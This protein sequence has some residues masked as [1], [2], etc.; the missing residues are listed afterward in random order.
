M[1][2]SNKKNIM[3]TPKLIAATIP[4]AIILSLTMNSNDMIVSTQNVDTVLLQIE[5][6][7]ENIIDATIPQDAT[8]LFSVA[9]GESLAGLLGAIATW[10]VNL[11]IAR[12]ENKN[13]L[14]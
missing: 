8:D 14:A 4:I 1:T 12:I 13:I 9:L 2:R 6:S 3:M 11:G 5:G 10:G 7:V